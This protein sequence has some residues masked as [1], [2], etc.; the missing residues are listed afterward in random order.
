[1]MAAMRTLEHDTRLTAGQ[2]ACVR[3]P[4]PF[5]ASRTRQF[6]FLEQHGNQ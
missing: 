3:D 2:V 5:Y 1:M 4:H 6:G